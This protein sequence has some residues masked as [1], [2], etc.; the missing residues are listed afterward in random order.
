MNHGKPAFKKQAPATRTRWR[1]GI[2]PPLPSPP[3]S[4]LVSRASPAFASRVR[5]PRPPARRSRAGVARRHGGDDLLLGRAGWASLAELDLCEHQVVIVGASSFLREPTLYSSS[6]PIETSLESL[7]PAASL[8][9]PDLLSAALS[10]TRKV[11]RNVSACTMVGVFCAHQ[12]G[13]LEARRSLAIRKTTISI[14]S[15]ILKCCECCFERG[16]MS[17]DLAQLSSFH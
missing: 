10:G 1:L 4:R 5:R 2:A 16:N 7:R 12:C 8:F 3:P 6:E 9:K 13:Q 17:Y 15:P 11:S 14:P